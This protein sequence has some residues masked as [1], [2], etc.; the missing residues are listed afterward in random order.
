MRFDSAEKMKYLLNIK[1]RDEAVGF[2]DNL[3]I[4][5]HKTMLSDNKNLLRFSKVIESA[6]HALSSINKNANIALQH[7]NFILN[8]HRKSSD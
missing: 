2:Y 7:A 5:L 1:K 6:T 3:I 4:Y 8:I